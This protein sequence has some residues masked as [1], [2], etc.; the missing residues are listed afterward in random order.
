MIRFLEVFS[1]GK[2]TLNSSSKDVMLKSRL[3]IG[4]GFLI[5]W[6]GEMTTERMRCPYL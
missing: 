5:A 3:S 6:L 1:P 2:L 4:A